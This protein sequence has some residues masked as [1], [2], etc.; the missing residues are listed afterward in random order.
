[1][2]QLLQLEGLKKTVLREIPVLAVSPDP[3]D[4]TRFLVDRVAES[5]G[6][7]L[8]HRFLTD[9][10]LA[11]AK[12]FGVKREKTLRPQPAPS[13][14]LFDRNGHEVW[15]FIEEGEKIRPSDDQIRTEVAALR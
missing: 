4:R 9:S 15:R 14:F 8:T 3:P 10:D 11:F 12:A 1:V 6:V 13:W 2:G 5:R 7:R